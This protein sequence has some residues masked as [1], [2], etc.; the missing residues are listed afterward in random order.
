MRKNPDPMR[1]VTTEVIAGHPGEWSVSGWLR[2]GPPVWALALFYAAY[3]GSATLGDG[4]SL[5]PGVAV[6]FWPPVGIVI[7]TLLLSPRAYWPWWIVTGCAAELTCNA[8]LW[9]NPLPIALVY[10][11]ANALEPLVAAYVIGRFTPKPFR[12]E[13][14]EQAIS[15][16]VLAVV[17]TPAVSATVIATAEAARGAHTFATVWPLVWLGDATGLLVSTPLT[18]VALQTW[19]ERSLIRG[20]RFF[21]A[22]A[23]LVLLLGVAILCFEQYLPTV[24][25][26]MPFLLWIAMRFGLLGASAAMGLLTLLT[27]AF[28]VA[29]TEGFVAS[30]DVPHARVVGFQ[31]FLGLSAVSAL[32]VAALSQQRAEALDALESANLD[33]ER[34]VTEQTGD[35]IESEHRLRL[36]TEAAATGIWEWDIAEDRV[37]WTD[38]VYKIVGVGRQEFDGTNAAFS[39][40]IHPADRG[41]ESNAVSSALESNTACECEFRI[42]RPNGDTRWVY[43]R[44]R[45]VRDA[46]G[47]KMLGTITDITARKEAEAELRCYRETLE[48]TVKERTNELAEAITELQEE[49]RRRSLVENERQMLLARL[50][51]VQEEERRRI[52]QD[53][54]DQLGQQLTALNMKIRSAL[55]S[56]PEESEPAEHLREARAMM[57]RIDDD[58]D[59]LAWQLR[60]AILDEGFLPALRRYVADWSKRWG[61][62]A[63]FWSD[64]YFARNGC[65]TPEAETNLYRITQ[66]ALNN[67]AKYAKATRVEVLLNKRRG[68]C[69]L[70]VQD[71]GV[72]FSE[73]EAKSADAKSM[74]LIGMRERAG[75][76]GGAFQIESYPG[77]GTAV[78]VQVPLAPAEADGSGLMQT[79]GS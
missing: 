34:R 42:V 44:G 16:L 72:G 75:L 70:M 1:N 48:A 61:V 15:L 55:N 57:R 71:N 41:R 50:V 59:A 30:A 7:V 64:E 65:L 37:E 76:V 24:Y 9:H 14:T 36:A 35:L 28:N 6:T 79:S 23:A 19:R 58:V 69:V 13:T 38:Q 5:I 77:E 4:L 3:V 47:P 40:M 8:F 31:V 17:L 32:F 21:E 53:L 51:A 52:A 66:E 54:H 10:F 12:F 49:N 27:A 33:L 18:F 11:A 74:G 39:M 46:R 29:E 2:E 22:G 68:E 60:P 67:I 20:A 73:D 78:Y 62:A 56:S 45:P 43:Y 25:L 26:T 63:E